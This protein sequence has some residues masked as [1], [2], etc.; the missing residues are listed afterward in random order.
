MNV[1]PLTLALACSTALAA[2]VDPADVISRQS[3][4]P[5]GEM[6]N[7]LKD[8]DANQMSL[9][10]CAWRDRVVAEQRLQDAIDDKVEKSLALESNAW[11][12]RSLH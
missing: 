10:F 3:G 6:R 5:V 9:I 4:L 1:A 2:T 8:C 12:T 7:M 11:R